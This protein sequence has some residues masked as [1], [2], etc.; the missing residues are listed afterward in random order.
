MR[1]TSL[2][3]VCS[4]QTTPREQ[5]APGAVRTV[6]GKSKGGCARA[7][8]LARGAGH[9]APL[10]KAGAG[11]HTRGTGEGSRR[12]TGMARPPCSLTDPPEA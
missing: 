3:L 1:T 5:R 9:R 8:V 10:D 4:H 12:K 7:R 11:R 2:H 6:K